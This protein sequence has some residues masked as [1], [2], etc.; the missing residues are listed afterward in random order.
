MSVLF[1]PNNGIVQD[2]RGRKPAGTEAAY[3]AGIIDGEGSIVEQRYLR[4]SDGTH[5]L[6]YVIT[7][8]NTEKSLMDWLVQFGG[9]IRANKQKVPVAF[10]G[11]KTYFGKKQCYSWRTY[12]RSEVIDILRATLPFLIL[13]KDKAQQAFNYSVAITVER[14]QK[15]NAAFV[16]KT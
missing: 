1:M 8:A 11:Q 10:V 4:K 6:W 7:V 15:A 9:T 12:R 13:K 5:R 2:P 3:L 14:I 16:T